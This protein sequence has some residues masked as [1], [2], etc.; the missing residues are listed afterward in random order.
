LSLTATDDPGSVSKNVAL[1]PS[2]K[3]ILK[4][5]QAL[6]EFFVRFWLSAV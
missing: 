2:S 6:I 3:S 1:E 4:K 5:A